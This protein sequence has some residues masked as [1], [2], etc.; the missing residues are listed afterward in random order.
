VVEECRRLRRGG[1]PG[2]TVSEAAFAEAARFVAMVLGEIRLAGPPPS[3][4]PA[5][6]RKG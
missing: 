6:R 4:G 2:A 3:P 5:G 1:L